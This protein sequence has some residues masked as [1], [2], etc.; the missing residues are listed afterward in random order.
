LVYTTRV[1]YG[2][3]TRITARPPADT[4]RIAAEI[5]EMIRRLGVNLNPGIAG[6]AVVMILERHDLTN[7]EVMD[8]L[9]EVERYGMI[10]DLL[11]LIHD[12]RFRAYLMEKEVPWPYV[13]HNYRSN[14]NDSGVLF[15]GFL[16]G[17]GENLIDAV[18]AVRLVAVLAGSPFSE[19]LADERDEFFS[20]I[21]SFFDNPVVMA[22]AGVAQL[23]NTFVDHLYHLRFY[24]A[25]VI[26]GHVTIT[27]LTLPSAV[28]SLPSAA[29]AII[30]T[31]TVLSRLTLR[32]VRALGVAVRDVVRF[33]LRPRSVMVTNEGF[34][35]M[36]GGDD[37]LIIR[38][39]GSPAGRISRDAVLREV[40]ESGGPHGSGREPLDTPFNEAEL[41]EWARRWDAEV[42]GRASSSEQTP[43]SVVPPFSLVE[44]EDI[45]SVAIRNIR[46][47]LGPQWL[48]ARHYGT[49]LHEEVEAI[50]R[51]R[52]GT[53]A[54]WAISVEQKIDDFAHVPQRVKDMTIRE[55]IQRTPAL[56]EYEDL[57]ERIFRSLD[58]RVGDKIP[59]L[60]IRNQGNL[61]IWDLTARLRTEHLAKSLFYAHVLR[62]SGQFVHIGETYWRH[63]RRGFNPFDFYGVPSATSTARQTESAS[64][65]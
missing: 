11:Q 42:E 13:F 62:E 35:M 19:E 22:Q 1:V 63:F 33:A 49:R 17:V 26:L 14:F 4:R 3:Q 6:N 47:R 50:I 10:V 39:N 29:R 45:V 23:Y 56:V 25:G 18:Y 27:L 37:I 57:L 44:L 21:A 61:V 54:G 46:N 28:R 64:G 7:E 53:S 30:R 48:R 8:V 24:E 38:P 58:S 31:A 2:A 15:A 32:A 43:R 16:I 52:H 65:E 34:M 12:P 55:F 59:D 36:S 51:Q 5:V 60:V 20:A 40:S 9:Q 41:D